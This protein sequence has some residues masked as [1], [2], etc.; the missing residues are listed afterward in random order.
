MLAIHYVEVYINLIKNLNIII[1]GTS[2]GIG[3]VLTR[4]FLK[5]GN[6]VWGCSRS[7][8]KIID[9]N[10]FHSKVDL[11]NKKEIK[12]W[13]RKIEKQSNNKVDLF[14]SNAAQ[15]IRKLHSLDSLDAIEDAI[16]INLITP[17][18]ISN[19]V[20]KIMI[21]N[22]SGLIVF[23]SSVAV[24]L[25][26]IGSSTYAASKAGIETF[27]K[28]ANNELKNFNIKVATIRI[29]YIPTQLSNKLS[30]KEIKN[31]IKKFKTNLFKN[32]NNLFKKIDEIYHS[33]SILKK[34]IFFDVKKIKNNYE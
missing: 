33:K 21:K 28:V 19:M 3:L 14:I 13:I 2:S 6:K 18:I 5:N 26:Q 12:L 1:T 10:Y 34:N 23:F 22:K 9:K 27:S 4:K 32:I 25:N 16:K 20:S 31:L 24:E 17:I 15:F 11:R 29:L 30:K 7:K 8:K